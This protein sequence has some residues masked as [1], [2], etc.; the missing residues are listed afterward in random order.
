MNA[1]LVSG[2]LALALLPLLAAGAR[3]EVM[4]NEVRP[5]G[6]RFVELH[7]T[8]S[9][10]APLAGLHLTGDLRFAFPAGTEL[11]AGGYLIVSSGGRA[12][13]RAAYGELPASVGFLGGLSGGPCASGRLRLL[14]L[15]GEPL[16]EVRWRAC[17]AAESLQRRVPGP[18]RGALAWSAAR[19]TPGAPNGLGAAALALDLPSVVPDS[20]GA[21]RAVP[22]AVR[23]FSPREARV[24]VRW[25]TRLGAG[26][27]E[28]R[29]DPEG[30]GA[31]DAR[32]D[33]EAGAGER[34]GRWFR[35]EL[36]PQPAWTLVAYRFAA[37]DEAGAAVE[38]AEDEER[39]E[40]LRYYVTGA[41]EPSPETLCLELPPAELARLLEA[42]ERR[43]F[44]AAL[45]ALR[46]DT[47]EVHSGVKLQVRGGDWTRLWVKRAWVVHFRPGRPFQGAVSL[48][49]R[50]GWHDPTLLRD[51][52]GFELYRRLG[53][54]A[55]RARWVRL[56]LNGEPAGVF[57]AT[58]MI[59]E[60]FLARVGL[61]GGVLYQARP[62]Q[63]GS[64]ERADG[65]RYETPRGYEVHWRKVTHQD[66]PY[67]DLRAFIE[68]YTARSGEELERF[69]RA[70]LE[71]ERYLDYL[72]VTVALSHWDSAIKNYYWC[73][74][75][76]GSG[77]WLVIPW[78]LDRTW[79]DHFEGD[80]HDSD[81]IL[82]GTEACQVGGKRR[83]W[84]RLRDRFLSVPGFRHRLHQRI[85][86]LLRGPL[87]PGALIHEFR[88]RIAA[89]RPALLEDRVRW[90]AYER[91]S[92]GEDGEDVFRRGACKP[93][94]FLDQGL[95]VLERYTR[96][97]A[98]F[99]QG[100]CRTYFD[101]HPEARPRSAL[102][103]RPG[104]AP[105]PAPG[106]GAS[107][108]PEDAR[109][110][111]ERG[112]LWALSCCLGIYALS[113]GLSRGAPL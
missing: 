56:L 55:P 90:G 84:N 28:L 45:I 95:E 92:A 25:S 61:A 81:P 23:L 59:D 16:D 89:A 76:E 104:A 21:G 101:Q 109:A 51:L 73:L 40:P 93:A 36:P 42:P 98:T 68:G 32:A 30:A 86:E 54:P 13:F 4:L 19:P 105:A 113:G 31:E 53:V 77:K 63:R 52:M 75:R 87:E 47:A 91:V 46:G 22:V 8:G 94:L 14:D 48:N 20:V 41:R 58:E 88:N 67:D 64:T 83:W 5:T 79:G 106:G 10:P 82:L 78:D 12:A 111:V 100:A 96:Q 110:R 15:A 71:V 27:V 65:R 103:T 33:A 49:L 6:L 102:T 85:Q 80:G 43:R 1:R 7:N 2:P 74:D 107:P 38:L 70:H 24:E 60:R 57:T 97:R 29:A 26:S 99:L 62:P 50:S 39:D 108:P 17:A 72:A 112:L 66:E 35:G 44:S 18:C 34:R 9:G 69:F 37:R 3:A 11:A